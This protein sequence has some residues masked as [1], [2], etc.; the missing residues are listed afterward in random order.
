MI[1]IFQN[2]FTREVDLLGF[3]PTPKNM[4][5]YFEALPRSFALGHV[6]NGFKQ[7]QIVS[8]KW[9]DKWWEQNDFKNQCIEI[10]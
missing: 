5:I 2:H 3:V 6:S 7:F 10:I 1:R 8:Q 9:W 4:W